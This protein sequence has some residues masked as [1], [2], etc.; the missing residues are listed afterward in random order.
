MVFYFILCEWKPNGVNIKVKISQMILP[1]V[2]PLQINAALHISPYYININ[3]TKITSNIIH[4]KFV[5]D[6]KELINFCS[7]GT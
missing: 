2:I 4:I 5:V 1:L 7:S 3:I 6:L